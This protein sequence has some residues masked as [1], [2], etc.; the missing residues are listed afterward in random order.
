MRASWTSVANKDYFLQA[1]GE[2]SWF[3]IDD[4]LALSELL[5]TLLKNRDNRSRGVK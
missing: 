4:L 3:H 1:S 2:R 5:K